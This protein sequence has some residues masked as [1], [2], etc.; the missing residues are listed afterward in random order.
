MQ[1]SSVEGAQGICPAGWHIPTDAEQYA[2]EDFLK[3]A[4]QPCDSN[5]NGAWSCSSAGARLILGGISG[6]DAVLTGSRSLAGYG[7]RGNGTFFWS[8]NRWVGFTTYVWSRQLGSLLNSVRR[9]D[10]MNNF[11][12]SVRCIK[13]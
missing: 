10:F 8:S 1:Y 7:S 6:F 11:G 3:D 2:L 4:G 9:Y 12:G 13:N 5:R